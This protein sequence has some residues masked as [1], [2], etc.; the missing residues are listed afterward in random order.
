MSATHTPPSRFAAALSTLPEWERAVDDVLT[1]LLPQIAGPP[2]LMVIFVSPHHADA[3]E[4]IGKLLGQHLG[5]EKIL[6]CTAESVVGGEWE[7]E[8]NPAL[9]VWT[10]TF[11][12]VQITPLTLTLVRTPEG[13]VIDGWP[14]DCLDEW[15]ADS[16]L[17]VLGDPYT[18]P[19][20]LLLERLNEDRPGIRVVG[21]MASAAS[22]PGENRLLLGSNLRSDGAVAVLLRGPVGMRTVVS[23]GCRPVG[24][25]FV[26]T[27]AEQNILHEL[28]GRPALEQL[29]LMYQQLPTRDQRL[30]RTGLQVGR[31]VSEYRETFEP[32][33]FLMR[34]VTGVDP[35]YGI[36]SVGDYIRTGQTIQFHIRDH[37]SADDDLRRMLASV[38]NDSHFRVAGALLFTCNGRGTSLFPQPH[39]DAQSIRK[40]L[41]DVPTAGFFAAGELGPVGRDN[42]VH[43]FTA[44]I[45]LFVDELPPTG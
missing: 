31:V 16:A 27:R 32:G 39:H 26:V 4:R 19:A 35:R 11:P 29:T 25:P 3:L 17:I 1:T 14:D 15:P 43:G 22:Q 12:G 36:I 8:R 44:S 5:V 28:G 13:G 33:D 38:A 18:F 6:G 7:I 20:D 45:A 37:E 30:A 2:D 10:G 9:A 41:G 21:G 24:R 40:A 42:F 23:Q 34:N